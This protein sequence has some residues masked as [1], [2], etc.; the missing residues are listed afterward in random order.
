MKKQFVSFVIAG[1]LTG[2]LVSCN[3]EAENKKLQEA[4]DQAVSTLTQSKLDQLNSSLQAECA[5]KVEETAK[6]KFD[7]LQ[8]AA[9][10]SA[11]KP[12]KP[13][14][15][16]PAP[17]PAKPEG[18]KEG[19]MGGSQGGGSTESKAERMGGSEGSSSKAAKASRMGGGQKP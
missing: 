7:S 10:A 15:K 17:A 9:M 13:T 16:K 5:A 18:G 6:L 11:K 4:D 19:R 2:V 3:N 1:M 14:V 12:V 8:A